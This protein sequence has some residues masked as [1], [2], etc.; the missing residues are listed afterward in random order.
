M[1][2]WLFDG[3]TGLRALTSDGK[4]STLPG[5][6]EPLIK[7]KAIELKGDTPDEQESYG[8]DRGSWVLPFQ[9]TQHHRNSRLRGIARLDMPS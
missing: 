7:V 4:G 8:P 3:G 2:V 6:L 9:V 5:E 1:N